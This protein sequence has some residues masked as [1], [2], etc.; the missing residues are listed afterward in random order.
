MKYFPLLLVLALCVIPAQLG[1]AQSLSL[2]DHVEVGLFADCFRLGRTDAALNYIGLG[3]RLAFNLHP[4]AQIEGEMAYDFD[5]NYTNT[6]NNLVTTELV[7][8]K[9]TFRF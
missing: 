6:F 7:K 1:S 3:G 5:R 9:T 4:N 8:V 2:K